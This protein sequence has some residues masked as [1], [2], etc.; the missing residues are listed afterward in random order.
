M[1]TPEMAQS[2]DAIPQPRWMTD[3]GLVEATY[4]DPLPGIIELAPE[5][6][7]ALHIVPHQTPEEMESWFAV[8][9]A[10][11][12]IADRRLL[13]K[14]LEEGRE[15]KHLRPVDDE[16]STSFVGQ[17]TV[18]QL[19]TRPFA[20]GMRVKSTAEERAEAEAILRWHSRHVNSH[21]KR[22]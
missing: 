12:R 1:A 10:A 22:S 11:Q 20:K 3:I 5:N 21:N 7:V 13:R 19:R 8:K 17:A 14:Q 4:D 18:E 6:P 16:E 15:P 2:Q 9:T